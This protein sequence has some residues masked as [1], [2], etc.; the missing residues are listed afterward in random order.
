MRLAIFD[1]DG[2]LFSGPSTEKRFAAWLWRRRLLGPRR[3]LAFLYFFVRW[4]FRFGA[5]V[6]KKNK[7]YLVGLDAELIN[8]E[9]LEFVNAEVVPSLRPQ[10]LDRLHQHQRAGDKVVLL[11]GTLDSIA[12]ALGQNLKVDR[13]IGSSCSL[14][15]GCFTS[16]PPSRHPFGAS[17][18]ELLTDL[19]SDFSVD[20]T[21]VFAYGD[22]IHDLPLLAVVGYPIAV[23]PDRELSVEVMKRNWQQI[24]PN[25]ESTASPV[26]EAAGL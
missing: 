8:S 16:E 14:R 5:D 21:D 10:V 6:S 20:I 15:Q 4:G 13:S 22:S 19:C 3:I 7:A 2:T 24:G 9:A 25:G 18:Q 26:G 1:I 17:K 11:S 23:H 12:A